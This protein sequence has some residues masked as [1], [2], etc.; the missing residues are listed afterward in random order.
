MGSNLRKF[1]LGALATG[2]AAA[3]ALVV[4]LFGSTAVGWTPETRGLSAAPGAILPATVSPA[5]PVTIVSTALDKHGRPVVTTRTATD[6]NTAAG[7]IRAGQTAPRAVAV[8]LDAPT[9]ALAVP[10]GT[11]TYRSLQYGLD[12]I[13]AEAAWPES[14][15]AGVT[16]AVLDT[17]VDAAHP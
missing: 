6:A 10:T 12:T 2:T 13:R 11:D 3:A 15:A 16:V 14:T 17:G 4:P 1:G 7:L 5:H 9:T 8:E